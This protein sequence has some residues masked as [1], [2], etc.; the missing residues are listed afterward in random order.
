M[1]RY[2]HF[3]QCDY[4]PHRI[5]PFLHLYHD[6]SERKPPGRD[7]DNS[8]SEKLAKLESYN[9]S[10]FLVIAKEALGLTFKETLDSSY[11]LIEMLLQEYSFMMRERNKTPDK[12][13]EIEGRDFEW[14]ELPSFDNPN[15]KV[16]MKKYHDIGGKV[17]S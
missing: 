6:A 16:R 5:S 15:E 10:R 12:D 14:V 11:E 7:G 9:P 3:T 4:I 1:G 17:K 8:R 2:T 13:G